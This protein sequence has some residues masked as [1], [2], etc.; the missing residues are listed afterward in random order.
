M[1]KHL[2]SLFVALMATAVSL[3]ARTVLIDES[4]E[5]G[6]SEDV[7]TQEFVLGETPW[8]VESVEDNLAWPSTVQEG[9]HRAYLRNTTGETQGYKTRLVSKVMDLRPTRV[10]LPSLTFWYA[11]PRWGADRDTLRVF[12]RTSSYSAWKQMAEFS[13]ASSDWQRVKLSLPEVGQTY[14]IAFEGTDNLGRGIVLD[15]IKLQSAPDCTVPSDIVAFNKGAGK[16]NIAWTASW[17]AENFEVIVSKDTIDP[18]MIEQIEVETPEKITYHALVSGSTQNV[19]VNLVSGEFYLVYVR[20]L[21]DEENSAWSSEVTEEG[22]FGFRVRATKQVPFTEQFNYAAGVT[23]DPDW[24]WGSNTGNTNPY[25]NSSQKGDARAYFSP[26][27][28]AALIFSGGSMTSPST[29]IPADRYVYLATPALADSTNDDFQVSQC[30]VHFWSTV[31]TYTGR[32]YGRSIVVGVMDDPDDITTFVPVD[33]VSVWGNKTF[34]ENIVDLGTYTGTGA[35]V[36]FVSDFDRQN[37][38]YIDNLTIEYRKQINKVTGITVNPRDTYADISWEGNASSYDVLITNVEVNPD[39]PASDAVVA[40]AVV[41]A[42]TYRCTS[43]EPD[44]SWNRP[45]YVYVKAAGTEWSYR[46]PFVTIAS[47]RA[48]PY[49]FDFEA[50]TTTK[51]S[52]TGV[53]GQYAEGLGVFGNSGSYPAVQLNSANSY[54]GSGYLFMSKR[55]GTDTWITLPM[56]ENLS[57]VQVKFYLSG[58][59]TFNQS[60]ATLG[61]MSNPMDI[62]TFVPVSHFTLNTSGYTRCYANF[63]N[64]NGPEGVIAIMWDDV[65]RM[66]ENT[67][68]YIDEII[69]E[70]LSECVPPTNMELSIEPDSVTVSWEISQSDE[71]ELFISRVAIKE[72]DRVHKSK[73]ELAAM[74]GVV[75]AQTLT[76][77]TAGV[78]P[79]FG[80]G[81]LIP[82][83]NYYLYVRA[84]CDSE[85]WS[86]TMFATPCKDETFPYKETFES[87]N[88]G[89]SSAGCWQ[90][91]DYMGVGYPVIYNAGTYSSPNRMLRLY[92]SGTTHRSL[93]ILPTVEGNL[94][95]MLL[96]FDVKAYSSYNAAVLY[97]GTME[98]IENTS[99]FVPFDTVFVNGTA[100][101]KVRLF[102]SNYN[103]A[104][105][106]IAVTSG[107]GALMMSSDVLIDNVELKDPSC[108]E[109][110]D[111]NQPS[112]APHDI[113]LTWSGTTD[114]DTWEVKVMSANVAVSAVK[115][116]TY[117]AANV[118]LDDT[119]VIGKSFRLS[120]LDA[121]HTYYVYV[122][123]LCGDSTWVN[124]PVVTSCE[125]LDPTKS[126]KETFDTYVS[127][128]GSVPNC[129]YSGNAASN[130]TSEYI[131]YIYYDTYS[132]YSSS[133][134]NVFRMYG[135]SYYNYTPAYVVSPE[136][137]CDSLSQIMVTFNMYASTSYAWVCGVMSD[138]YD[139][140]TFVVIDSVA[141]QDKSVQYSYD[142]SDYAAAIPATAKYFAWRTPYNITSAAYLDDVS[143]VS[144]A[145]PLTKPSISELTNSSVRVSSGLRTDDPWILLVTTRAVS[146]TNLSDENYVVPESL[147]VFRDTIDRR[148]KE[149]FGLE[150][151]TKYFVATASLCEDAMSPWS[152]F[153]FTTPCKAQTPEALGTVTFSEAEG[154]TTGSGG[155]APCWT[156]GSK[157]QGL[158][159]SYIPYI[160]STSSTMHNNRNYLQ[161]YDYV[162]SS[163]NYVGAYAIMPELDVDSISKYQVSFWGRSYNYSSYNNQVIVGIV[164]DPSD[165]NTFVAID[166]LNLS[167]NTWDPYSVGFENYEGDYMGV[168][169]KNI[170]FLSDFGTTNYAYISE[171][172]VEL[173]PKCRSVSSF[174]VDSVGENAAVISWK[175]YQDSYRLL[176]ADRA[177][178]DNE[179]A[180]YKYL[181]DTVV[182]H[183]DEVRI[184][185]LK[186]NTYYYFYAQGICADGDST[187]VS[188]TYAAVRT[189]CP[190]EGGAP[191]PFYDDFESYESGETQP[192]CWQLLYT[193]T[194]SSYFMV[195]TVSSNG[196]KAINLY[197]NSNSY[198]YGSVGG[199]YVV[200]PR[201]EGNLENLQL[202]FDAR[203]YYSSESSRI[204]VGV[205]ADVNDVTT[206]VLLK[207]FNLAATTA[208]THC[209][210]DLGDYEL[211]YDNLVITSGIP[212]VTLGAYDVYLD[213]VSLEMLATCNS[214]K[215]RLVSASFNSAELSLT[216]AKEEDSHWQIVFVTETEYATIGDITQYLESAQKIEVTSTEV[217]LT[218]LLSATSYYVY[219]RAVC[220]DDEVSTWT[221]N[222]LKFSTRF[223][224]GENYFFGF[225]KTDELWERSILSESDGSYLHPALVAGR[226]SLGANVQS[227]MYYPHCIENTASLTSARN[228]TGAL[229]LHA[230][231]NTYGGYVIFPALDIPHDRSFEFKVRPGYIDGDSKLAKHSFNSCFEIGT[232][233][234]DKGFETYQTL[235][236]LHLDKLNPTTK[237]TA[238]NNQLFGNYSLDLDSAT[239]ATRQLVLFLPKQPSDT[240][241]IFFDDV[242]MNAP[243]G[244]NLVSLKNITT[245]GESAL[246]EWNN[247]GGPWNLYVTTSA[248]V[249]VTQFLNLSGVTSQLV[250]Q[251]NPQTDYIARL[252]AANPPAAAN[253]YVTSDKLA[254]RTRCLPLE[255][256]AQHSFVWDFNASS[257]WEGNDVVAGEATDSLYLKPACFTVA[258]T[259][260]TPLNGYQWLVQRKGYEAQGPMTG[261]NAANAHLEVG[262]GDSPAL[263]IHTT[264]A[265]Y[266]SYLVLPKL[267][268][269]LDTMMIEFYGRC[270]T[271]YDQTYTTAASRGK[272][273]NASFLAPEY[274]HSIVVGTLGNPSDFSSLQVLDTVTYTHT[275]LTT[276]TNVNDDPDGLRYWEQMRM[277]LTGAQGDY[278]VL[279]QPAPGLF[280]LDDLSVKPIGNTMFAP[281]GTKVLN[282]TATSATLAWNTR[283]PEASS[284]VVLLGATGEEVLRDTVEG[285]QYALTALEPGMNYRWYVY[286]VRDEE[287]SPASKPLA[288]VTDCALITPDY[289]CGFEPEEGWEAI[290]GQAAY[291]QTLCW[292]YGDAENGKWLSGTYDPYNQ[293][294]TDA[295]LY[296]Y[297]GRQAVMMRASYSTRGTSYRP[298]IAL[299]QMDVAAYDTLQL[300]FMIRPAF[301]SA[302]DNA[303]VQSFTG[304]TYSKSV[305]VGTMTDPALPATF[306]PID[307]VTYDGTLSAANIANSAN[308]FLFEEAKVELAGAAGPYIALMTSFYQKGGTSQKTGDFIWI[309]DI[310]FE[311]SSECKNPVNLEALQVGATH[312]VL[313]WNGVDSAASYLLQVS[314]DP[315]FAD[316]D[317][318]V[319]NKEVK[320]DTFTV[321]GLEPLT[322]YV[323]RVQS[324]CGE[325]WGTSAFSQKATFN[326]SRSPYFLET[327]DAAVNSNEWT[328]SKSHA[329]N[330]L[331]QDGAVVKGVDN[332][333]FKRTLSGYGLEGAHYEAL[334]Y[335]ADFHWL[336]TPAFY[337]PEDDSVHFSMDLALTACNTAH[338]A[339]ANEVTENDMKDDYYFMIIISDDG[340][341]TWKS[342]NI[343]DKWQNTNPVGKQLRDIPA[344]GMRVRY[345]LAPYAGKNICIGL[346][347]EAKTVSNTGVAVHVDNVR[348]AYF[349]KEVESVSA[350]QYEDITIGSIFL[351]GEDTE[352]G[353]HAYPTPVYVSHADALAGKRDSV[354]QLE[355]EVFA[356]QETFF[357]DT[358][359]EGETYTNY[360]FLPKDRSG[361][362]HRKLHSVLHGCD[363]IVT[364]TL[365][366][367]PRRYAEEEEVAICPGETFVW[368]NR[369][370]D[371]A[372]L[373]RDTLVSSLGC[374]SVMTLIVSYMP[375]ATDTVYARSTVDVTE[376]PFTYFDPSHLYM[377]GQAA[378]YYPAG[379]P[380][381]VYNDTVRVAG[382]A[383]STTL[384][385]TL[386]I[387]DRHEDIDLILDGKEGARKLIY[388]DNL[389]IIIN[390]EWYNAAGQ[391][392]ADP[393]TP[394][395]HR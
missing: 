145:C 45:Y 127:G 378:I 139:L 345:S 13:T 294:N 191:L 2:L 158:S 224:Y 376:L 343:L 3:N 168:M 363:S 174:S 213:N 386:T 165:L 84:T 75:V 202:S 297:S 186:P 103:L 144:V 170:M 206:F 161:L 115:N 358:I 82:H 12:Y 32:Q 244:F 280:Y 169:G 288:F 220:G 268:V 74:S 193:G 40:Q 89:S 212:S 243:K 147:V 126:N 51:Y 109:P 33:T 377:P 361:V 234:K 58:G 255:P 274:S 254:F 293:A 100:L 235:A 233:E 128:T 365:N 43:L 326:T 113:S 188:M 369:T 189:T 257:D 20:S 340:G 284:V 258:A 309:D 162:S 312:A 285:T 341:Q 9:T 360:D 241:N 265:A 334:G 187:A 230:S 349:D 15:D 57:D 263:R 131:P 141:G 295:Y 289:T 95:D 130:A 177:L 28:T 236:T 190:T 231:A 30:Q 16:V 132:Y 310:A 81:N 225:E 68:N 129:W 330:I 271:S 219:A 5:N 114:Q 153:S 10:Y 393:T 92:S 262:R 302:T 34:V 71:W 1:K 364:L 6:I 142:L 39:S 338:T 156:L 215:L 196:S 346:Y 138:P 123:A 276:N 218:D 124:T 298:Y 304:S 91:T 357:A 94:S 108:I 179:K 300:R 242:T 381:G 347:R 336:I 63:E 370:Y 143:F 172:S 306:V 389:Y 366:V 209:T 175:G 56:V 385:H 387:T 307:T 125:L 195:T 29:F 155:E 395:R 301:V 355:V 359:C 259:Y 140:S 22:P 211:P 18:D 201:V 152:T 119:L 93:A 354:Y 133:G 237:A 62:N 55:G 250:G 199:S 102:L 7:W 311:R 104:Y 150:A 79:Q 70:E 350:C 283:H 38:F 277:P 229:M 342:A 251:L 85:W 83:T 344:T 249:A 35:Y 281:T 134:T 61:V 335:S 185:N 296:S 252:E 353:I 21:C 118:V 314:T 111:F 362:Y 163:Y 319:F 17:D 96:C 291:T 73:E 216:P 325:K 217:E 204:Y 148:S 90:L 290:N 382:E 266:N 379:T 194:R 176:L 65:M 86:E 323:W 253:S 60:H 198:S 331:D 256:D 282:L 333:S 367:L 47:Q 267:N 46:Y 80:F 321:Q 372:G 373:F 248:G 245:D 36:A 348:L 14:Q 383:C 76:W 371:R 327:F 308:N 287:D 183:S 207:T 275:D 272:I 42:N 50:S 200:L 122:R 324:V 238:K 160:G 222:P 72:S 192:G 388:R 4:F 260:D 44:H 67:I 203:A 246:V 210:M 329:D 66:S 339:T 49:S 247:I 292:T 273:S 121:E 299:P 101:K 117:S 77:N 374:D 232:V 54:A 208:F 173:I 328:F 19:D 197:S 69:V 78:K 27:T 24:S 380:A 205:M 226:D 269:A 178:E 180:T 384:V 137:K 25:V 99:S 390:D 171:V 322:S 37:L 106:H 26:D 368:N 332:W 240:A 214:P 31:Y 313:T 146:E 149:V 261:Y 221:R 167:R 136:I 52:I 87:Y 391:K 116:G 279:F 135:Y 356:A 278:I 286:Q 305:I 8:A 98:D 159:S 182:N 105:D 48:I 181:L 223:Y 392:V 41:N 107:M 151:Q 316:E 394:A 88:A 228:G 351:S 157:T 264:D 337:L 64:Y 239:V 270:F 11:N 320:A 154:F 120:G 53:T 303:V 97:V 166:T 375:S 318:F 352:P 110:Y 317:A 184:R 227:Y 315:Y 112:Y 59:T 164:S 23:R